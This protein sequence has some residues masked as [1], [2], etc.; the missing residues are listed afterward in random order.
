MIP[1]I[2]CLGEG[3]GTWSEAAKILKENWSET[4]IVCPEFVA[5]KWQ[6]NQKLIVVDDKANIEELTLKLA[7]EFKDKFFGDVA[8]NFISG[9]GKLHMALIAALLKCGVGIRLVISSDKGVKEL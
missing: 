7:N 2:I 3:K 4:Y 1:L 9:S 5:K 6:G 8:I